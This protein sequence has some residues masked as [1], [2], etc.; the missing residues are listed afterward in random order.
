MNPQTSRLI[1]SWLQI[2]R[3]APLFKKVQA[4]TEKCI[5]LLLD[6]SPPLKSVLLGNRSARALVM[7]GALSFSPHSASL[8]QSQ[9]PILRPSVAVKI[10]AH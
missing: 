6:D 8:T 3:E 5:P 10:Q 7:C 1:G 4:E 2:L 9:G